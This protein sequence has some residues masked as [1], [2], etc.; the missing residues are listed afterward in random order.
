MQTQSAAVLAFA[1]AVLAAPAKAG[2][3][4]V[5]ILLGS[6]HVGASG[7]EE[8]NPGL[9][10]TWTEAAF[11][12]RADLS[13]GGFRNS[14]GDGSVAVSLALPLIRR[15]FWGIDAFTALAWYPGHGDRFEFAVGDLVPIA[16]LQTRLGPTFI[17][18]IPGGDSA[19]DATVT[20][21]LT[22]PLAD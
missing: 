7:F 16:G 4:Q 12:G 3:D 1:L 20:F 15:E 19:V 18:F 17:Q 22:F 2:P 9:F 21:G 13:I 6:E 10:L 5:S 8:V 14:Y 11:Q